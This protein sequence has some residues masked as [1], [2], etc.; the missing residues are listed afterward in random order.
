MVDMNL[1]ARYGFRTPMALMEFL[2]TYVIETPEELERAYFQVYGNRMTQEDAES[3]FLTSLPHSI[4][5]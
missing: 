1:L 3:L 5:F 4:Y 2:D